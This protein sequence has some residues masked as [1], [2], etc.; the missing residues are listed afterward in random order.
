MALCLTV[1]KDWLY[2]VIGLSS[3]ALLKYVSIPV[4]STIFTYFHIWVALYMTFYPVKFLGCLQIPGTN[5]GCGWQGIVPNRAEEMANIAVDNLLKVIKLR[6]VT[7]RIDP[8]ET[9]DHLGPALNRLISDIVHTMA[10]EEMPSVWEKLPDM[11]KSELVQ[12]VREDIPQTIAIMLNEV[13]E[14]IELHIDLKKM[15]AKALVDDPNLLNNI[16]IVTG[17]SELVFIR[18]FGATMGLV[19]GIIQVILW[20]FYSEGWMLPTFGAVVGSGTNW[21]ALKMIFE[22]VEPVRL[23]GGRLVLQGLFLKR[24]PEAAAAFSK[25][26]AETVMSSKELIREIFTSKSCDRLFDMTH[27]HI[28]EFCDSYVVRVARPFMRGQTKD[29]FKR[30]KTDVGDFVLRELPKT[31]RYAEKYFQVAMDLEAE[32]TI[33]MAAMSPTDFEQMLHPV[34]Q[35]DEWKLI[36][37]GGVLGVVVGVCQ[38]WALGS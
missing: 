23:C 17:Y 16:F 13:K 24:Q 12:K 7:D 30:C 38:W 22:P 29:K 37:L 18:N 1:W 25:V 36:L 20:I 34:F 35:Q 8:L 33:R 26:I 31:M 10:V 15:V 5:V 4:V 2:T 21:I 11:V 14:N 9:I 28:H 6:D 32:L 19:F 27:R 3:E